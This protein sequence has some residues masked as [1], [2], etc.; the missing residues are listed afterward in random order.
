MTLLGITALTLSLLSGAP[1]SDSA[2][3][4]TRVE[5]PK[6][7]EKALTGRLLIGVSL[8][9]ARFKVRG[10]VEKKIPWRFT[11]PLGSFLELQIRDIK[12]HEYFDIFAGF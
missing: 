10:N 8:H 11:L 3:P 9:G 4:Q 5:A 1:E 12:D 2:Q 7:E 6:S